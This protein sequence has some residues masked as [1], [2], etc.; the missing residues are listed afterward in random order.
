[1]VVV[2]ALPFGI[3]L[4]LGARAKPLS[5]RSNLCQK[6]ITFPPR[7][8][9]CQGPLMPADASLDARPEFSPEDTRDYV[10]DMLGELAQMAERNGDAALSAG[11]RDLVEMITSRAELH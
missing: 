7:V 3:G 2:A 9:F 1:M 11:I 4:E 5:L 6:I 8:A 10:V